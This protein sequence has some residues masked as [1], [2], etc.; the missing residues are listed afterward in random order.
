MVFHSL[1][2]LFKNQKSIILK[3]NQNRGAVRKLSRRAAI[4]SISD[5]QFREVL[6]KSGVRFDNLGSMNHHLPIRISTK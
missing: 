1:F 2:A 5:R 6:Q 4:D 3:F